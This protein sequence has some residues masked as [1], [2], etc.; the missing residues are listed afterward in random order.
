LTFGG[1]PTIVTLLD[2][3]DVHVVC[4]DGTLI[5]IERKSMS[6]FLNSLKDDRVFR[7][8]ADMRHV[9]PWAYLVITDQFQRGPNGKVITDRETGW[10]YNALQGALLT[11]QELGVFVVFAAGETDFEGCILRLAARSHEP[12][13]LLPPE[14]PGVSLSIAEQFLCGLPNIGPERAAHLMDYCGTAKMA[15]IALTGPDVLPGIPSNVKTNARRVLGLDDG[16][17]M[18]TDVPEL[19][20]AK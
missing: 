18:A 4:E 13:K 1:A 19:E 12:E 9:S 10:S 15:L 17:V 16:E 3:G 2:T 20:T 14:R 5:L 8:C 6:D 11:I 7:Q